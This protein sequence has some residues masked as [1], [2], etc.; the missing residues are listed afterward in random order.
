[1]QIRLLTALE[2][3]THSTHYDTQHPAY[4]DI[5]HDHTLIHDPYNCLLDSITRPGTYSQLI[6]LYAAKVLLCPLA[7]SHTAHQHT[8]SSSGLT[9][10]QGRSVAEGCRQ[11]P[12]QLSP[13]CGQ[14]GASRVRQSPSARTTS[15][16]YTRGQRRHYRR[17]PA[18]DVLHPVPAQSRRK[19]QSKSLH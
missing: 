12:H 18:K 7:Y 19:I 17:P 3:I 11:T 5:I 6:I 2:I 4:Q 13:S 9:H 16:C 8:Q 10:Y 15:Y 1:M 14:R